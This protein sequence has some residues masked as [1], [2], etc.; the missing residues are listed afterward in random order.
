MSQH[1]RPSYATCA[2]SKRLAKAVALADDIP[3][4]VAELRQRAARTQHLEA[5]ILSTRRSPDDLTALVN[6]VEATCRAKLAA[7]R[8]ALTN[9]TDRREVLLALFPAGLS[10]SPTRTP[11]GSRQVWKIQ[12]DADL[13]PLAGSDRVRTRC[14]GMRRSMPIQVPGTLRS[15]AVV[16]N[17]SRPRRGTMQTKPGARISLKFLA[18]SVRGAA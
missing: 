17:E 6:Q 1:W 11:A 12:G 13:G 14:L 10:F 16:L 7:L 8:A 2:R 18:L 15:A 4:L 3:E 9:P 5:Q